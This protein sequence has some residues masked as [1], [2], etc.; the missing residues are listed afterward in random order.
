MEDHYRYMSKLP[1]FGELLQQAVKEGP[2]LPTF[3]VHHVVNFTYGN[4]IFISHKALPESEDVFKRFGRVFEQTYTRFFDLQTAEAQALEANKRASVDRV[5]AEIASMRT[6]ADLEKIIPLIWNELTTLGVL[7]IRCGVFI[8]DEKEEEVHTFLSNAE[9]EAIAAFRLP[10]A[11]NGN[12]PK[13]VENWR[14]KQIFKDH[15]DEAEFRERSKE[16]LEQSDFTSNEKY[17]R[18]VP[19]NLHSFLPPQCLCGNRDT[20]RRRRIATGAEPPTHS[21]PH[22]RYEDNKLEAA[23]QRLR[24]H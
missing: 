9:G 17:R 20:T 4:Q 19:T 18:K 5:R 6:T 12:I 14:R 8:M 24:I 3:Q 22:A 21:P 7:F 15:W 2:P 11:A 23:K 1:I 13:V 16:L 10:F